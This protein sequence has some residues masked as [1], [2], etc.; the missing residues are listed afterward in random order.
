MISVGLIG[1]GSWG[2]NLARNIDAL[3]D[4]HVTAVCDIGPAR[5]AEAASHYE[6]VDAF[7]DYRAVL[8]GPSDAV[9]IATPARTHFGI[10]REAL[11]AGKHVLVEKPMALTAADAEALVE[12]AERAERVLMVG[13]LLEYHPAV[14][15]LRELIGTGTLGRVLFIYGRRVNLGRVRSDE[16]ALWCLGPHDVSVAGY[17]L[18]GAPTQAWA[19]GGSFLRDDIEDVVFMAV[20]YS[21]GV[22]LHSHFSW[23][24]PGKVRAIT[25]VGDRA[26]AVFDDGEPVDKLRVFERCV[27]LPRAVGDPPRYHDQGARTVSLPDTEPLRREC[28]HFIDC[29]QTGARPRSD[30]HDGLRVV[31]VLEAA[32]QSLRD[33]GRPVAVAG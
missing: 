29:I 10:A 21:G 25:V 30:G 8:Q 26:M 7:P 18:D 32:Q 22:L 11:A 28:Q 15:R 27:E 33:Q 19:V 31:R 20:R 2:P 3:D 24:D 1:Y 6:T 5:L 23:L 4:A 14:E 16:N 13:H 9:I 17:L 12:E